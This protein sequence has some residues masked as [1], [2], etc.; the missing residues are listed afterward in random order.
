MVM[1]TVTPPSPHIKC[2]FEIEACK[3]KLLFNTLGVVRV[4]ALGT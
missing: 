4:A 2:I 3:G 1:V